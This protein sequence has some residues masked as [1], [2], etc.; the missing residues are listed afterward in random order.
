[1]RI[2]FVALGSSAAALVLV[3]FA[4]VGSLTI[5]STGCST[6]LCAGGRL[7]FPVHGGP[8]GEM[9]DEDTYETNPIVTDPNDGSRPWLPFNGRELLTVTFPPEA[10]EDHWGPRPPWIYAYV[11][12]DKTP[13]FGPSFVFGDNFAPAAGGLAE[14]NFWSSTS[15]WSRTGPAPTTSRASWSTSPRETSMPDR[16]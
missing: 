14:F 16:T 8:A 11:G 2:G 4:F 3:T 12:T 7:D 9:L 13:N 6:R 10:Q 5:S 15:F 1:M